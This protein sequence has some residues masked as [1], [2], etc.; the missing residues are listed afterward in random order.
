MWNIRKCQ[1]TNSKAKSQHS[2]SL[3]NQMEFK[4][5]TSEATSTESNIRTEKEMADKDKIKYVL[6]YWQLLDRGLLVKGKPLN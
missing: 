2:E 5:E 4:M 6:L 1:A 3:G